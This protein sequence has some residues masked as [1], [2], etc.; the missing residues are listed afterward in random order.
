VVNTEDDIVETEVALRQPEVVNGGGRQLLDEPAQVVRKVPYRSAGERYRQVRPLQ[1]A[2]RQQLAED[3]EGVA[4]SYFLFA[5]PDEG[6][7][8]AEAPQ[9]GK[10]LRPHEGVPPQPGRVHATVQE[11]AERARRQRV[12][13]VCGGR[14]K[15]DFFDERPGDGHISHSPVTSL[16]ELYTQL[17]RPA[18]RRADTAP[19]RGCDKIPVCHR[20]RPGTS[21]DAI[22]SR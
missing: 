4:F 16:M 18:N 8:I 14:G 11:E 9:H 13:H 7:L 22:T 20:Q 17:P 19:P 5:V 12:E 10:R 3:V 21:A 2:G 6:Y 1:P 15:L